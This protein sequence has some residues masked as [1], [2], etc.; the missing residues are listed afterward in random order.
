[1]RNNIDFTYEYSKVNLFQTRVNILKGKYKGIE[2]EFGQSGVMSGL[3]KPLFDFQYQ[4][5]TAPNNFIVTSKFEDFLKDLSLQFDLTNQIIHRG[6]ALDALGGFCD[7]ELVV[8]KGDDLALEVG[9]FRDALLR[10]D[11]VGR[12]RRLDAQHRNRRA[13][14]DGAQGVVGAQFQNHRVGLG[15]E[16]PF[17]P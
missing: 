11:L 14:V 8:Y 6:K 10:E 9:K 7:D 3:G 17:Q 13:L 1:M 4:L 2:V 15:G 5:Y 12:L 16:R